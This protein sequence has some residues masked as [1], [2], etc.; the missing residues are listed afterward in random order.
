MNI[1]P[2]FL[3]KNFRTTVMM[4]IVMVNGL[5]DISIKKKTDIR[6]VIDIHTIVYVK[7]IKKAFSFNIFYVTR[8]HVN[9][10]SVIN[11]ISCNVPVLCIITEIY[12]TTLY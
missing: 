12:V 11:P 5:K 7:E 1:S 8:R 3:N 2:A 10:Y 9:L 4:L 6:Q